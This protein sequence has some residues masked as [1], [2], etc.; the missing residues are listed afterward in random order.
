M[1]GEPPETAGDTIMPVSA[2]PPTPNL[3]VACL[4]GV[5]S[6]SHFSSRSAVASL[7][8][9][10]VGTGVRIRQPSTRLRMVR[11]K[12]WN[13][14][15][16]GSRRRCSEALRLLGAL[17]ASR[18]RAVWRAVRRSFPAA[19][20]GLATMEPV[21]AA[22]G[23]ILDGTTACGPGAGPLHGF[24]VASVVANIRSAMCGSARGPPRLRMGLLCIISC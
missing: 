12:G 4:L 22:V 17:V 15:L 9:L 18:A 6:L 5:P 16:A 13:R 3:L 24:P 10:C 23:Q 21:E 11:V 1:L 8:A 2:A 19:P 20:P 14:G 7:C